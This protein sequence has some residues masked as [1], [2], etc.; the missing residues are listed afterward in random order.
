[1]EEGATG[2]TREATRERSGRG[3]GEGTID[4]RRSQAFLESRARAKARDKR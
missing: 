2:L 3:M 4:W 1:M